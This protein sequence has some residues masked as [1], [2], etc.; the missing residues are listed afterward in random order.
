MS[1]SMKNIVLFVT[2]L[3]KAKTFYA[4]LLG[5]PMA[6]ESQM[7]M[8]FFPGSATTLGIALALQDDAK[9]LV[10]RYT[11]ISLN[12][13]GIDKLCDRLKAG[14]A[15]FIEPLEE[16]PWGKMAVVADPDGNQFALVE[17]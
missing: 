4:D 6:G 17:M 12:V 8:E 11:G 3:Q 10:G 2:D 9:A 1:V 14:G 5:L 13:K 7:M 16:S 15:T